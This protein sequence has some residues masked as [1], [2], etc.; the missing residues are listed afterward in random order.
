MSDK[1]PP[2]SSDAIDAGCTCPVVDNGHGKGRF[3][4]SDQYVYSMDCE[5]HDDALEQ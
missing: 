3:G 1:H 4:D 2:G 5:Y